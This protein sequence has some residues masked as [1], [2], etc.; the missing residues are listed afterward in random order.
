[1]RNGR[2][3]L[4][5]AAAAFVMCAQD[6]AAVSGRIVDARGGAPLARVRAR[7]L[8]TELEARSD[9]QGRFLLSPVPPGEHV[10]QVETVG[11]RLVKQPFSIRDQKTV[12]FDI[13]LSPETSQRLDTVEVKADI[14]DT[15]DAT[16]ANG[17]LTLTGAEIKNLGTVMLDDPIR[18]VQALPGVAA[19][20]DY[21]SRFTVHGAG[22][23]HIGLYLDDVLMH[24][25]FHAISGEGDGSLAMVNG[26]MVSDMALL[27]NAPPVE[28]SDRTAGFLVV[29]TREG[30]RTK[31][32]FRIAGGVAG[33]SALGEGPLAHGRGS[34]IVAARKSYV[35]YLLSRLSTD[36]ALAL[37]FTDYQGKVAYALTDRQN[38]SL[39]V[40]DGVT[41]LDRSS[42]RSRSG[43]NAL[44]GGRTRSTLVKANWQDTVTPKLLLNVTG[45]FI[46]ERTS[47]SNKFDLPIEAGF[48]GEWTGAASAVYQFKG[49]N[50][51]QAGWDARRL[52]DDGA[53]L[54]YL[55]DQF[56]VRQQDAHRGTALRQGGYAGETWSALKGRIHGAVGVRWDGHESYHTTPTSPQASAAFRLPLGPELQFGWGQYVQ[57]PELAQITSPMGGARLAPERANHYSVAVEQRAGGD[58]RIRVEAWNR[59]DRDRIS[60]PLLDPRLINN[61]VTLGTNVN[62]YNSTRG[63]SRGVTVLAQRRSANRLS[64]WVS[65][66][67][68][69]A[70]E[71]DSMAGA[72]YW[73]IH[74]QR[75]IANVYLSYRLTSSLNL[76]GRWSYGSG[77]PIPGY[78]KSRSGLYYLAP[79]RNDLR[80]PSY[81]RADLR[82]NKS[83]TYD[84]WK[85]TL[86][87]EV[88]N[89]TN[90][91]NMR[92]V[93]FDGVNSSTQR[94]SLTIDRV[95]P[96]LPVA[97]VTLEF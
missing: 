74:D 82:V 87:G 12:E 55:N 47:T 61:Q 78:L 20:N 30:S 19:N 96:I 91:R 68:G 77:E 89:V 54:Y 72:S 10:L 23:E 40:L 29:R 81:Q 79:T 34:W 42:A 66:T 48:Y 4:I 27:V 53:S 60:Q 21:Q 8:G 88:I 95:F 93:S 51:F 17:E 45:A 76:S 35:Q 31:P 80:L 1:M 7:V 64:G 2:L 13:K 37:G 41:D 84:R 59:D 44:I 50:A 28:Y 75:H 92:F 70:R 25:P 73:S 16:N 3:A 71:R 43:V 18:A 90:H 32:S 5:A 97:G 24:S 65:Y 58:S 11:Y 6:G 36:N 67:L 52:R 57:F 9:A 94:A 83:F 38:V 22:F 86:Y 15:A 46:R 63:Y 14:F 39:F 56:H 26:E 33:S 69:Y 62:Y 49:A 85:L